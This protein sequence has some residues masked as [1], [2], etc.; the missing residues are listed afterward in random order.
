N[1]KMIS[2]ATALDLLGPDYRY[3]TRLLG[4]G[5]D[6]EGTVAGDVYLHGSYDP[7]LG[8][9]GLEDLAARVAA[10]GVK[11]ITGD[12][13]VGS[14]PT[15]DG[16]YRS[17]IGIDVTAG[18]PGAAPR[19][20]ISPADDFVEVK[21]EATTGRRARVKGSVA[22]TS[23]LV[24]RPDGHAHLVVTVRGTIGKGKHVARA[25]VTKERA[26]NAAYLLRAALRRHGVELDGDVAV[27]ELPA[28]V[29]AL[30]GGGHLPVALGEHK[31]AALADIIT[32]VNKRSI[33]WLS[34]RVVATAAMNGSDEAPTV[35]DGVEAMYAWLDHRAGIH[36]SDAVVDTGSGLSYR[37]QL[38][39]RQLV[40]V[41]R[42]ATGLAHGSGAPA[43]GRAAACAKAFTHSLS[44]AGVDGTLRARFHDALRGRVIAKTGTLSDVI[45]LSGV[46]TGPAGHRIVFSLVTNGHDRS[47]KRTIRAGHEQVLAILD[48]YLAMTA[49]KKAAA[50]SA[51]PVVA[52]RD[53]APAPATSPEAAAVAEPAPAA[54]P[55]EAPDAAFDGAPAAAS[56]SDGDDDSPADSPDDVD[57]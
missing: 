43:D 4:P 47:R 17:R 21:N 16:L 24:T 50:E 55:D 32:Q 57:P 1:V 56:D 46:L 31:S 29:N 18:A 27:R 25:I 40:S 22:V 23:E 7:T 45:A 52:A 2:T 30:A 5:A 8:A 37:T 39:T 20:E 28:Y 11:R 33:N 35:E 12:V 34:D 38:S 48:H 6:A 13:L 53:A 41:L 15:R 49:P 3:R 26:L 51:E 10:G 54:E 19:V 36:R 44:I 14:V 9:D 42:A